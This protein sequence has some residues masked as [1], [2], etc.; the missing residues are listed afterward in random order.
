MAFPFFVV[1]DISR[2]MARS[3]KQT[4]FCFFFYMPGVSFH[5]KDIMILV[6][7]YIEEGFCHHGDIVNDSVQSMKMDKD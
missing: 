4:Q 6:I 2:I 7:Y 5:C 3:L 1:S